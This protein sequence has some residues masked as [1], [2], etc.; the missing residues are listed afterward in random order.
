MHTEVVVPVLIPLRI[1]RPPVAVLNR[2]PL[3][4]Q[5]VAV[6]TALMSAVQICAMFAPYVRPI[7][8]VLCVNFV[9][10]A[11]LRRD[12]LAFFV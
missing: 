3:T 9:D 8:W 7:L 4:I 1:N 2:L 5:I 12:W 11:A 6:A 10:F